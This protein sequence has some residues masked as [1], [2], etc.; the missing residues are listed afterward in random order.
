MG[1][2]LQICGFMPGYTVWTF[3]GE[4]AQRTRDE[5]LRRRTDDYGTG[6]EDMVN[7]FDDA[8]N[9]DEEMEES[10]KAFYAMLESSKR[11]LH[12]HTK[13]CQ[14]DAIAQVMALKAQFNLGRDCYDAMMTLFGRF[15]PEGHIMPANLYHSD[16]ILSA[17]KMPYEQIHACEKGCALFRKEYADENYCPVCKSSRYVE[18][19]N[20]EG[21]KKQSKIP[22]NI[23]RYLPILPRLQRLY[24]LEETAKQ[25]TWH[26][27]GIRKEKDEHGNTMLIHPSDGEAWKAFD[28]IHKAKAKEAR[29][30]RLAI[31]LDGFNPFGMTATQYSCWPVFIMPL[32]L[33]LESLCKE[34]TFS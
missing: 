11:P 7:D 24:M 8:R 6:I 15:L 19:D 29:N 27:Y 12:E 18:V 22:V 1:K 34:S 30:I 3:H 26:K 25:M 10:A 2:H 14:L 5:V 28:R 32:N 23:L 4:S 17:L 20:G 9:E 13:L 16:K 33:P 21:E 31:S